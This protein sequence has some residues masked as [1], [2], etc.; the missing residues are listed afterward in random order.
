LSAAVKILAVNWQDLQNPHS[1]G[2]EIH[3]F[4]ILTRLARR[5]ND[6]TVLCSGF[7]GAAQQTMRDGVEVHRV[8]GRFSFPRYAR[9]Y[10]RRHLASRRFDV[11]LDDINKVPLFT[12]MWGSSAPVVALVPHL[13]G[14]TAFRELPAPLAAVVWAS[15]RPIPFV[16]RH[17]LFHAIS[18]S[19][20]DDLVARGISRDRI[21]VI[22]PG[23]DSASYTPEPAARSPAPLFI[24]LGRLKKYKGI[25]L[26]IHALARMKSVDA[27]LHVAGTGDHRTALEKLAGQLRLESRVKFLGF[28]D[29]NEKRAMLRSAWALVFTSPKEGWGITNLEAQAS[30]TP[31]IAS[32]SPGLRE[33]LLDGESGVLVPHGDVAR[34]ASAMDSLAESPQK[35]ALMGERGRQFSMG[36]SW[37]RTAEQTEMHI[38]E[39]I[40][41]ARRAPR[42]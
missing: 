29:E 35:V 6:V 40:E 13:F 30:G 32:D 3:L 42:T 27:Q 18:R 4:E 39:A 10:F 2:A 20:A 37:E 41:R 38:K 11:L 34:L 22:Y 5:G 31:V 15:E 1:G 16:Y 21:T 8:G 23:I 26:I 12:P 33:S 25:D 36:F 17:S 19:T 9:S 14:T 28:V 7:A 24:Y